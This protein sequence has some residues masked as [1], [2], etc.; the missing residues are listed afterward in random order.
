M[1]I[2][3]GSTTGP[4]T[5]STARASP[6]RMAE[7][8]AMQRAAE[9]MRPEGERICYDPYAIRFVDPEVLQYAAAHPAEVEAKL[10]EMERLF[11]GLDNSIRARTRYFDDAVEAMCNEGLEQLVILG[12]GYDTRAYR[13]SG[14]E[15]QVRTFEVDHPGT[16]RFKVEKVR[17]LFGGL[18]EH[19][20]YVPLDLERGELGD[21]LRANGYSAAKRTLF[22]LEGLVMYLTP[23]AVDEVLSFVAHHA[24]DGSA[25]LFDYYPAS[26]VDG[27]SGLEVAR[28]IREFTRAAGEPLRFGI[29]DGTI[30][31]FL[32]E[33]G[34][35]RVRDVSSA[36]YRRLYFHGRNA[37]R[38]VCELLSFV[39]AE[40]P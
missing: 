18:P 33:R 23:M 35:S 10:A 21:R 13:L 9:S 2:E 8:M 31:G 38:Q 15:G 4:G 3:G 20:A 11:P 29:P 28:N 16:Q 36:E 32:E 26:T 5:S 17:E 30:V 22:V 1:E 24:G 39:S 25:V 12:A 19:V 6:S 14:L 34:F 40:V 7:G 27:S 37:D